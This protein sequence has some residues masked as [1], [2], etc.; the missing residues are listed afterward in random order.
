VVQGPSKLD[1]GVG[2][3]VQLVSWLAGPYPVRVRP[4]L[5]MSSWGLAAH[6]VRL[7]TPEELAQHGLA[8]L[9]GGQL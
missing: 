9:F 2:E 5:V 3:L 7:A 8:S 1:P 4:R 6:W